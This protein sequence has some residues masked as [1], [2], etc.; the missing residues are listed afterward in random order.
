MAS[1]RTVPKKHAFTPTSTCIKATKVIL[2]PVLMVKDEL[3]CSIF[4]PVFSADPGS[5]QSV[6]WCVQPRAYQ[7][8]QVKT[9]RQELGQNGRQ[10]GQ[11][12]T[13]CVVM[14]VKALL[15]L[16]NRLRSDAD[17]PS[18]SQC[19]HSATGWCCMS[20]CERQ[21]W[22]STGNTTHTLDWFFIVNTGDWYNT[23]HFSKIQY[24][25]YKLTIN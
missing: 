2:V 19:C 20:M 16:T 9:M 11:Q 7:E 1:H 10:W 8:F 5:V 24:T 12:S 14:T 23:N 3:T 13:V 21:H 4:T 15:D 25:E 17:V 22:S 18:H 6:F